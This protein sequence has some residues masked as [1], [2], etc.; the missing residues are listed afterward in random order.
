MTLDLTKGR[1]LRNVVIHIDIWANQKTGSFVYLWL[2]THARF[3]AMWFSTLV[4][5][6]D[7]ISR[8]LSIS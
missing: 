3:D 4:G 7:V 5:A 1:I 8:V 2:R 6:S